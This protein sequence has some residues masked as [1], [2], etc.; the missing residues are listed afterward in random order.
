MSCKY[1]K[2]GAHL[3]DNCPEIICKKCRIVGHP[4]W[5][6]KNANKIAPT[7]HA[8][9]DIPSP[10]TSPAPTPVHVPAHVPAHLPTTSIESVGGIF[11]RNVNVVANTKMDTYADAVCNA[12]NK[13]AYY[14]KYQGV[15]WNL[16]I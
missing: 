8:K 6:C 10:T 9:K 13:I 4:F 14:M 7:I 16:M 5:K 3:I 11:N 12:D 15:R 1:C 2:K